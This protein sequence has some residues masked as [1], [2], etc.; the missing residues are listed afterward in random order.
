MIASYSMG[1]S[2]E[3]VLLPAASVVCAFDPGHDR[4]S[5]LSYVTELIDAA[6]AADGISP[7]DLP[8]SPRGISANRI[9]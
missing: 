9:G 4:E 6:L 1:S 7:E 3:G 2:A 5:H 8:K